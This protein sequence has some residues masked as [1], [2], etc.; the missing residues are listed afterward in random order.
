[1]AKFL[2]ILKYVMPIFMRN[3]EK[4]R[5]WPSIEKNGW[6]ISVR[7]RFSVISYIEKD[8]LTKLEGELGEPS[9]IWISEKDCWEGPHGQPLTQSERD[10]IAER[11]LSTFTSGFVEIV[12]DE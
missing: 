9:V 7:G 8:R 3:N 1:M 5:K 12:T 11:I 10:M 2:D 6:T 4:K